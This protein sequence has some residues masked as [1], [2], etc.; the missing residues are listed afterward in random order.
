MIVNVKLPEWA[1]SL[2]IGDVN[3]DGK[4]EII[5]GLVNYTIQIYQIS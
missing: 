3:N 5:V 2:E 4:P 1:I